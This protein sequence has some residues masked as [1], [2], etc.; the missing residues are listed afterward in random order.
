M[1]SDDAAADEVDDYAED[2]LA[3]QISQIA[4]V[5]LVIVG[6]AAEAGDAR[7][8]RIPRARRAWA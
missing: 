5:G 3:Q 4:G 8:D 1:T 6:G 2:F 7:A